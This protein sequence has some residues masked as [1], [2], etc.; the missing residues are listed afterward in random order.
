VYGLFCTRVSEQRTLFGIKNRP[1]CKPLCTYCSPRIFAKIIQAH[2][3]KSSILDQLDLKSITIVLPIATYELTTCQ[4][5]SGFRVFSKGYK[6]SKKLNRGVLFGTSA[7]LS[8]SGTTSVRTGLNTVFKHIGLRVAN[9]DNM[10]TLSESCIL[11]IS[12]VGV[13]QTIQLLRG[14]RLQ[15]SLINRGILDKCLLKPIIL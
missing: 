14:N 9:Y 1:S 10:L 13:A 8:G 2:G 5:Y 3:Y 15:L 7:N 6:I 12:K 11:R 4:G